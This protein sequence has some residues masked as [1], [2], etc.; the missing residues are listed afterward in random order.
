[1]TKSR[2]VKR[3]KPI[4]QY[5]KFLSV[6]TD[7]ATRKTVVQRAPENVIKAI[8]NAS[9]NAC[10][11]DV[12]LTPAQK[13]KFKSQLRLLTHLNSRQLT[14]PAKRKLLVQKGGIAI[15]PILLSAVLPALGSLL[16]S[17]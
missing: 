8:C 17:K 9:V 10:N 14:L 7:P 6:C 4:K 11:G 5:I 3:K 1:M 2:D 16:F 13:K 12:R 15:L